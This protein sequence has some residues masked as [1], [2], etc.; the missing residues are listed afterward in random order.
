MSR[1]SVAFSRTPG[2]KT[3]P[4]TTKS[5]TFQPL[6][7]KFQG[8]RP[9]ERIRSRSSTTKMPK[10][11][12][13]IR[14][15][16]RPEA[17]VDALVRPE[18]EHQGVEED[19]RDDHRR[20]R[21][22]STSRAR[23]LRGIPFI[24]DINTGSVTVCARTNRAPG[25]RRAPRCRR[26]SMPSFGVYACALWLRLLRLRL[27]VGD[28]LRGGRL[29]LRRAS[30]RGRPGRGSR[31]GRPPSAG[32]RRSR[33]GC[34]SPSGGRPSRRRSRRSAGASCPIISRSA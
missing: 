18:P 26:R 2:M 14:W 6:R 30:R 34:A 4:I 28:A 8:R 13:L 20:E 22:E 19:H 23:R 5:K 11:R 10:Q 16:G 9:Y 31:S 33:S 1:S 15:S 29:D 17:L 27:A 7:K 3:E 12:S 25:C 24:R 21:G 32:T